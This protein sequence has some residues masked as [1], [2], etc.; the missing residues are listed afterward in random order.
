[1]SR[2]FTLIINRSDSRC[3]NCG[4]SANPAEA[5]HDTVIGYNPGPGCGQ[6]WVLVDTD[7]LGLDPTRT[8]PDLAPARDFGGR[9]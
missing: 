3:G 5:K 4:K 1:M 7:Y 2:P 9:P 6:R 8:R